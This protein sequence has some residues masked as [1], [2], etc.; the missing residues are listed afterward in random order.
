M[1]VSIAVPSWAT[2]L[3]SDLTDWKRSPVPVAAIHRFALPEDA[4]F[5]YA[6]L[7]ATGTAR[8]DPGNPWPPQ[9]P[10][11]DYARS[12]RG[13][14]YQPDPIAEVGTA[15]PSGQVLR[16]AIQS[17][18]LGQHRRYLVY[19]PAG[20]AGEK[21]PLVLFQDGMA[22]YAWG[23]VPQV[24]DRLL[25]AR[26]VRPAHLVFVPSRERA[27]EYAFNPDYRH[28]LVAELLPAVEARLR[29]SGERITWGASL[30]GL[31]SAWLAWEHPALFQMV[32][33]QSG[34]FHFPPDQGRIDPFQGGEWFLGT[35]ASSAGLPP[36]SLRWYLDCGTLE[37]FLASNR[38]L[39]KALRRQG[40]AVRF[41]TRAA[42]HN[43]VNWRN[44]LAGAFRCALGDSDVSGLP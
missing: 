26:Q 28:F 25:A 4:Y 8:P 10:W 24:F 13:P 38:R 7:D 1:I 16:A 15:R 34:A 6:F 9:N 41:Q 21:L 20:Y 22:Y 12:L 40:F 2:H 17:D 39:V 42:G 14:A 32:V 27:R 19:T 30:G 36:R 33:A 5:E 43:W 29:C 18:T 37:W 11:W 35:V 31:L 3:V 44:G 23:K